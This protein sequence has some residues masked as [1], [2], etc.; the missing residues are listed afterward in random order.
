MGEAHAF[1]EFA[2]VL[3]LASALGLIGLFLKQPLV[4]AFIATGIIVGPDVLNLVTEAEAVDLLAEIGIAAEA[5]A[6]TIANS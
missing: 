3:A 5:R 2:M 1:Y 4:V 6:R